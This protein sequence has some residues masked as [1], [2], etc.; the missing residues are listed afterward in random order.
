MSDFILSVDVE[1]ALQLFGAD[2]HKCCRILPRTEDNIWVVLCE[3]HQAVW[4]A[5]EKEIDA[6][7]NDQDG[8]K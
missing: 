6:K 1:T 3:T 7:T 8:A 2:C 4:S 5:F